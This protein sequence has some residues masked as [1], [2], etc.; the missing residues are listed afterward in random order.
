[1]TCHLP[2]DRQK[3]YADHLAKRLREDNHIKADRL[4]KKVEECI[5]IADMS[6]L[7]DEMKDA[8]DD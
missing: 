5:C 6:D 2:T 7:I 8:L 4:T 3:K 1:M